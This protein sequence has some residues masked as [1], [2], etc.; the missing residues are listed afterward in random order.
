[1]VGVD[2]RHRHPQRAA[3][4]LQQPAISRLAF[5][6]G[7][8]LFVIRINVARHPPYRDIESS[9]GFYPAWSVGF[10]HRLLVWGSPTVPVWSIP[11]GFCFSPA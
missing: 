1:M 4:S 2:I 11:T 10:P 3:A 6:F 7:A 8:A 5:A 9:V